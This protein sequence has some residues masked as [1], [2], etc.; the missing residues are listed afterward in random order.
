MD[1]HPKS[2][3]YLLPVMLVLLELGRRFRLRYKVQTES[4][5]IEIAI[6]ALL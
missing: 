6:F 1:F 5:A 4:N 3:L 2:A